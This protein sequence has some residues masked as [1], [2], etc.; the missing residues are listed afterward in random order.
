[1][2]VPRHRQVVLRFSDEEQ[3]LVRAAARAH[4]LAVG[5]WMGD[6]AVRVAST[7]A[8]ASAWELGLSRPE[9]LGVLIRVR[10]D[11]SLVLRLLQAD[12]GAPE[13]VRLIAA[14]MSRLDLL[15]DRTVE[16]DTRA[17]GDGQG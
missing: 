1:V 11:V 16:D 10:L 5:A 13:V 2:A 7:A 17:G 8:G 4:G 9:V 15:I 14:A 6:L 12:D 3:A